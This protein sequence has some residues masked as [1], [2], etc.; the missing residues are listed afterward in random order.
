CC[1]WRCSSHSTVRVCVSVSVYCCGPARISTIPILSR[2]SLFLRRGEGQGGGEG[3]AQ[4]V[5]AKMYEYD[6]QQIK[7]EALQS[8]AAAVIQQRWKEYCARREAEAA[9]LTTSDRGKLVAIAAAAAAAA[10]AGDTAAAGG[11]EA[12]EDPAVYLDEYVRL[13]EKR[14]DVIGRSLACQRQLARY[15]GGA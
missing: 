6:D 9:M 2:G 3:L 14:R 4:S 12:G 10:T 1:W 8:K 5:L 7:E 13:V 15:F 11:E